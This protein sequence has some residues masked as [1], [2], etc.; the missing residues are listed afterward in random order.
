MRIVGIAAGVFRDD[1]TGRGRFEAA[2]P[3]FFHVVG[4]EGDRGAVRQHFRA[5]RTDH[6]DHRPVFPAAIHGL[7]EAV[8]DTD[9]VGAGRASLSSAR[10]I[11]SARFRF[12]STNGLCVDSGSR[13][14]QR[15][16]N[17]E[18]ECVARG[19][20]HRGLDLTRGSQSDVH[21]EFLSGRDGPGDRRGEAQYLEGFEMRD[22]RGRRRTRVRDPDV[23]ETCREEL[24]PGFLFHDAVGG[25]DADFRRTCLLERFRAFDE[26][27]A[28]VDQVVDDDDFLSRDFALANR[29]LP[30]LTVPD[31]PA[32]DEGEEGR[33]VL[34]G[35]HGLEPLPGALVGE[36][37]RNVFAREPLLQ[38]LGTAL[39]LRR[40]V[41][42]EVVPDGQRVHVP[43]V[44]WD[45]SRTRR[46]HSRDHLSERRS[47]RDLSFVVD[48]L[49][50]PGGEVGQEDL[51]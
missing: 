16:G 28:G 38:K 29:D 40:D 15:Q 45:G 22:L 2:C 42:S 36:D 24:L 31:L 12:R 1:L 19:L 9:G 11:P 47:R 14:D 7:A 46:R 43:E 41:L 20:D 5:V 34:V 48:P 26:R 25:I 18:I 37:D 21:G 44:Q 33:P 17:R 30:R 23:G 10:P 35:E 3:S 13:G 8:L 27:A 51:E 49:H 4:G 6:R 32:D 39:E 50:C